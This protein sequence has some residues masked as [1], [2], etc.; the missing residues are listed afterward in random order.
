M[1]IDGKRYILYSGKPTVFNLWIIA[2]I[3]DGNVGCDHK[4][5]AEDLG[6]IK[7]D[8]FALWF[9]LGD[10]CDYI[11]ADDRRCDWETLDIPARDLGRLGTVLRERNE[12]RFGPI[13]DKCGGLLMG[14]H[15]WNYMNLKQ[16]MELHH[17]LCHNLEVPNLGYSAL[18]DLSF[19]RCA[20]YHSKPRMVVARFGEKRPGNGDVTTFRLYMHH[21]WGTARTAG[22]KIK[23]LVDGMSAFEADLYA[24]AHVH[25]EE[26]VHRMTRLGANESCTKAIQIQKLGVLTG[27]YLRTYKQGVTGYGERGG[28]PPSCLGAVQFQIKPFTREANA[29]VG[30]RLAA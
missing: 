16:Q 27:S 25:A 17:T 4:L 22:A 24:M 1:E 23:K 3:H 13:A 29:S 19:I 11:G 20:G 18:V 30:I 8:P 9:G 12:A 15:E 2:D 28:Y 5:L 7:A 21:G 6:K 26:S 10:Y 14:N